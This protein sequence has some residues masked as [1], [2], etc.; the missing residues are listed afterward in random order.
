MSHCCHNLLKGNDHPYDSG[1]VEGLK[2]KSQ[3]NFIESKEGIQ[4]PGNVKGYE[5]IILAHF[6][7]RKG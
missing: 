7:E 6:I 5:L 3:V 2:M 1:N 4:I